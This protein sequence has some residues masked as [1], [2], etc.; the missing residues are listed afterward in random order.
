MKNKKTVILIIIIAV[1][2]VLVA[3]LL[4]LLLK[5]GKENAGGKGVSGEITV[6]VSAWEGVSGRRCH[7]FLA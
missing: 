7:S 6:D 3:V 4:I 5:P 2:V 1:L